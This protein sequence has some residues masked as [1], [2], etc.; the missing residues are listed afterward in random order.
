M[1]L[2]T[3]IDSRVVRRADYRPPD[4][5]VEDIALTFDL[6]P[7]GTAVDSVLRLRRQGAPEVPLVLDGEQIE[8]LSVE[9]DGHLL[10]PAAYTIDERALTLPAPGARCELRLRGRIRPAANSTLMGLYVSRDMLLTQCEAQGMRRITWLP[11]RPDVLARYSVLL[12]A[13]RARYPVLLS[14]GNL[15]E[16]GELPGGRHYARWVDPH[17]KPSYLFALVAGPLACR[18]ERI[19][20]G[21]GREALLQIWS[22]PA[23]LPRLEH[24]ARSLRDAI[25][26]DERRFG[27]ELDLDRFMIVATG[28]FNMGAM[29]NKGLNIFN[30]K[31]VLADPAIA[32]DSD[33]AAIESVVGHEYF[34]NWSGNRVTCRD[35]FQLSLKEGLTVF[36][37]QEFTADLL[38]E[39]ARGAGEDPASARAIA[40]IDE[41]RK[42]RA[43]QFPEDAGPM[44]HPVR[45]DQYLEIS[46]FYTPT[47]YEK[48]A[49]VV[50]MLLTLL[51]REGFRR[52]LDRYFDRHDGQAVTCDEFVAAMAEAG[53]RD[54]S[55]FLR[56]YAQA[57]TPRLAVTCS[58]DAARRVFSLQVEQSCPPMPGAPPPQ[59]LLIPFAVGLPGPDGRD[60]PLRL[61]GEAA[62][63]PGTRVLEL[64]AARQR[65]D[66][67]DI[68]PGTVPSLLRN[69]SA[70]VIVEHAYDPAGLRLL[71]ACDRDPFNRWEAGQRIGLGALTAAIDAIETG[72]ARPPEAGGTWPGF[73]ACIEL[74]HLTLLDPDLSPAFQARALRLPDPGVLAE[75]RAVIDP[76]AIQAA[77]QELRRQL[78]R[79]LE[80]EW[81]A[82][83]RRLAQPT[84]YRP[85]VAAAGRRALK[86]LAL[87]YLV[88][89]GDA[90]ALELARRQFEAADNLTDRLA[91]LAALVDS[92]A[93]FKADALLQAARAWAGEPLLMNKWFALQATACALPGEPPVIERV[94]MLMRHAA[95]S[96][97]NPNNVYALVLGFCGGNPPEFHRRDGSGYA[98]W[99]EQVTRLDAIN[100]I[101]AARVARTLERWRRYTPDRQAL[102]RGA[103]EQ[104]ARAPRQSRDV[105]E[106][107]ERALAAAH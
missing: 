86:N 18:E 68:A 8:L 77:R 105:R 27:R 107:V 1:T 47:V 2:M 76:G 31:Y 92:A 26:W 87:A 90:A 89:S 13:D 6:D 45:P 36:R 88:D 3:T 37:D 25:A 62:A 85:E 15:V 93:P 55:Q 32:T 99:V 10:P 49:E 56:W 23:D 35:W 30:S 12:R 106:I 22:V 53:G 39:S 100:P 60:Q 51:G 71:A 102:M 57:G 82:T 50:R 11:D 78:G 59:P 91:A 94:R 83:Y 33:Y 101:V 58:Y 7:D 81:L 24:A 75:Q 17:P 79:A 64:H 61:E 52:G 65:F 4:Y 74:A 73:G 34:H 72:L 5:L 41:V 80:H 21:S 98:F 19:R 104:L 46:N 84:P 63:G 38:E 28:D 66:F 97:S 16:Q 44:A 103:L 48:G 40:R 54:L 95:Y 67:V 20:T 69:F 14:N 43:V 70:P 9:L 96:E 29:E 42:L